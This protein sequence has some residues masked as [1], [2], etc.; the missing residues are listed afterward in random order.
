MNLPDQAKKAGLLT[1]EQYEILLRTRPEEERWQLIDGVAVLMPPPTL[2]HQLIG[3]NLL[4]LLGNALDR[5]RPSLGAL[6]ESGLRIQGVPAFLPVPDLLVVDL[7]VGEGSYA[8]RFYL[9]GEILSDSNTQEY[10]SLKVERYA[11]H[12][13]NL[14]S[15]II[16]QREVCVEVWSRA[17]DWK[18]FV[19]RSAGDVLDLPEFGFRCEL[20]D[21]YRGTP[22][23]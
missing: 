15:L 2:R 12:P 4:R 10:I 1:A 20:R 11:Q 13:D 9:T 16:S 19:L 22:L 21:L 18:G 3:A 5:H 7:P 17:N 6:L 8:D 23:A 14:Y